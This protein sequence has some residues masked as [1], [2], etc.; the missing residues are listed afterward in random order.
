MA[1]VTEDSSNGGSFWAELFSGEFKGSPGENC[2]PAYTLA[3]WVAVWLGRGNYL[4]HCDR[5]FFPDLRD[6]SAG[7]YVIY[8][9]PILM[10]A[11]GMWMD[12]G[13]CAGRDL[14]HFPHRD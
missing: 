4:R 3:I 1:A 12:F 11:V 5:T 8:G 9:L 7:P 10:V 6:S 14:L 2:P 13:L